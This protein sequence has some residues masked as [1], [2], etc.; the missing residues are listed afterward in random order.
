MKPKENY[1]FSIF[2]GTHINTVL[3]SVD[4]NFIANTSISKAYYSWVKNMNVSAEEH[5]TA[6]L[7][8]LNLDSKNVSLVF[9]KFIYRYYFYIISEHKFYHLILINNFE[10][11]TMIW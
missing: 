10:M 6:T 4:V 11:S 1:T 5:H 9:Q 7:L 2:K 3:S 8:R